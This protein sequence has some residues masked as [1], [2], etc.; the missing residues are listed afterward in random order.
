MK[1]SANGR[2]LQLVAGCPPH[3][4]Y[5]GRK[6]S[7]EVKRSPRA[8]RIK[9][10]IDPRR[11][12]VLLLPKRASLAAGMTFLRQEIDWVASN[13]NRIPETVPFRDGVML[14]LLGRPH[15]ITHAPDQRGFVWA[16]GGHI[17][18]AGGEEH[19]PRRMKD[20]TRKMAKT[21]ISVWAAD[22]AEKIDVSYSGI[23]LRDQVSRWGSCSSTGRLNFS[24]RLLLMP[25]EVMTYIV[26][27]EVAHLRH[28]NH[29]AAFWAL[30]D[31]IHPR[32]DQAKKW[33]KRHGADLHKY[34]V[35]RVEGV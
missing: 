19:L 7:I 10:R 2:N 13:I 9:L 29:S 24:W 25:E 8:A 4:V 6:I 16:E 31:E 1:M 12:V 14:P 33:L 20:W 27:H 3:L 32:V 34:G 11:G 17:Y 30:V 22:Y 23:T 28:M 15:R 5:D 35:E 18:V 26:A 21:E